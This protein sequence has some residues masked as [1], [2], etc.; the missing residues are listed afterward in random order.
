MFNFLRK[1][2]LWIIAV[3]LLCLYTGAGLNQ[4][5]LTANHDKFPVMYNSYK[6]AQYEQDLEVKA[7]SDDDDTA[8]Q[9]QFDLLALGSG[10]LDDTHVIMTPRTHL[11]FLADWIDMKTATYSP[12]DVLIYLGEAAGDYSYVVW[13]FVVIGKLRKKDELEY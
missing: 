4:L 5:V 12:G 13:G 11:N 10:Y 8:Q 3:P 6:V 7:Q 1:T 9:A 2:A